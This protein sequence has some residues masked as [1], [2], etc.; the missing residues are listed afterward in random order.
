VTSSTR[1][2]E[3][4]LYRDDKHNY[5][6][7]AGPKMPGVTAS[8][9]PADDK[10]GLIG[11]AK[12]EVAAC[13]VRNFDFLQDLIA[14]G[15]V[16]NAINWLSRIPDFQRD[17]AA[18]IG[19]AVH[20]MAEKV[21]RGH[22]QEIP[23]DQRPFAEAYARFLR[24]YQPEF[25]SLEQ[26]VCNLTHHYGG[27]YDAIARVDGKR[28]L[29]DYKTSKTLQ[30]KIGLQL[31]AYAGAE[32]VGRIN[33]PKMYGRSKLG[34]DKFDQFAVLHIRPDQYARGYRLVRFEV[35][36]HTYEAFLHA[37]WLYAQWRKKAKDVIGESIPMPAV[38]EE[39]A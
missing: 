1:V 38:E 18:D 10:E 13:S 3:V 35:T 36:G 2:P 20:R 12:R 11:W 33:D 9:D 24:D 4:G 28:T 26:K 34:L 31:A 8:I 29:I 22:E 37:L 32:F 15:G 17:T 39:A 16:D 6:W 25:E 27:T 30:P 14:R 5:Y 19:S 23:E 7:N 21:V